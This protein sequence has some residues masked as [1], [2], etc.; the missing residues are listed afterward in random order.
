MWKKKRIAQETTN[1]KWG[2]E[3]RTILTRRPVVRLFVWGADDGNGKFLLPR[4]HTTV[5]VDGPRK[6]TTRKMISTPPQRRRRPP[7]LNLRGCALQLY[8][9]RHLEFKRWRWQKKHPPSDHSSQQPPYQSSL[10]PIDREKKYYYIYI[11]SDERARVGLM[12]F[13]QNWNVEKLCKH[14]TRNAWHDPTHIPHTLTHSTHINKYIH[15]HSLI[16]IYINR[17]S[18]YT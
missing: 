18:F 17:A 12:M 16:Y 3:T 1:L 7:P 13:R 4:R 14:N 11:A 2:R 6:T 10:R 15:T 5:A 9:G 8:P